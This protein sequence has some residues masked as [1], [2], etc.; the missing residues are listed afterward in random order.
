MT[1]RE[2]LHTMQDASGCI[3]PELANRIVDAHGLALCDYIEET[4]DVKFHVSE[5]AAWLG[6]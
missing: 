6:Y 3:Q 2:Q 1:L 4:Q 5:L